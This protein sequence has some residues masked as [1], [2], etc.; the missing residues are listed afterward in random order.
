MIDVPRATWFTTMRYHLTTPV[1]AFNTCMYNE[2]LHT[3]IADNADTLLEATMVELMDLALDGEEEEVVED[4]L[5]CGQPPV[6]C[7]EP[8]TANELEMAG[9]LFSRDHPHWG[10]GDSPTGGVVDQMTDVPKRRRA[11]ARIVVKYLR[12]GKLRF[13][14]P[15]RTQSNFTA[16]R[17]YVQ[18]QMDNDN[19]TERDQCKYLDTVVNMVFVPTDVEIQASQMHS[20]PSALARYSA[21]RAFGD[22]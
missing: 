14:V 2:D 5:T 13:G 11:N 8:L 17:K 21:H 19:T 18:G 15:K 16:V 1:R 3:T 7:A 12:K 22:C 20:E 9:G 10:E 4:R 6:L